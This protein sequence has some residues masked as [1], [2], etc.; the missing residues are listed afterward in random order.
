[1]KKQSSHNGRLR[2]GG[3][4]II[5]PPP[6]PRARKMLKRDQQVVSPSYPRDYPFVMDRGVGAQVWDVDRNRYIDWAAGIAVNATGHSHPKVVAAIQKQAEKFIH[7]SSDYYHE[8]MVHLG[9]RINEIAPMQEDVGVF[10][11]NSGTEAVEAAI[12]LARYATKRQRFLGFLGAFHGRSMGSLSFTASK[13]VQQE[14]FFPTM[15]GVVH[16]PFPDPYRPVLEMHRE[17]DYGDAVVDYIERVIFASVLPPDEVAAVLLEPIQG[18]G[19]YIVPPPNFFPRLRELCDKHGILLIADEIQS[20]VGRTGKWWAI[21]HW[22]V[23]PD[24]ICIAKGIASGVPL[25]LMA[26]RQSVMRKWVSGAHGNTYGGNPLACEAALATLDLVEHGMMANAAEMGEFIMDA[27]AEMQVRHPSI[28]DV[29]GRGLMIGVEF[30]QDKTSKQ[31]AHQLREDIVHHAFQNGLI[32]L[33]CGR[34]TL[35]IA[36]PLMIEKPLVEEGLELFEA[37]VTAAEKKHKML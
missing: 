23:E 11:A 31:P 2:T 24:I 10:F 3:E 37:A 30:V 17:G 7:I 34:S 21:Q 14:R 8:S 20:G 32:M 22:N 15:P 13:Y 9:E 6:G 33:G 4:R 25:G 5:I 18:E 19:G 26:A 36:P 12:K 1:M 28:G 27:L 29:R 35:R 16:V